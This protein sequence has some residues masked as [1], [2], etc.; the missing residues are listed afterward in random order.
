MVIDFTRLQRLWYMLLDR[1]S[2]PIWIGICSSLRQLHIEFEIGTT[3]VLD[4]VVLAKRSAWPMLEDLSLSCVRGSDE[5]YAVLLE[6]LP[7]LKY[8]SIP[9]ARQGGAA[10]FEPLRNRHFDSLRILDVS[11]FWKFGS[12]NVL[13][14]LQS[15]PQLEKFT[16]HRVL[17]KDLRSSPQAWVCLGLRC[18]RVFFASDPD[19]PGPGDS[20][21]FDQ[22]SRLRQLELLDVS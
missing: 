2:Q 19:E 8:L 10:Y 3:S 12:A 4:F 5:Q 18:L 17:L 22:L 7:P 16:A 11:D 1:S 13:K 9:Y 6:H 21:L 20:L 14:A 15:C